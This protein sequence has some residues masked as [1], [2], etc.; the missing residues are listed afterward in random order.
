MAHDPGTMAITVPKAEGGLTTARQTTG[1]GRG[2]QAL[3]RPP[4]AERAACAESCQTHALS[5][6]ISLVQIQAVV[7]SMLR[8]LTP[9]CWS[10]AAAAAKVVAAVAPRVAGGV[11]LRRSA[12]GSMWCTGNGGHEAGNC[13]GSVA[14]RS[15]RSG[16]KYLK[17]CAGRPA[18]IK[19]PV[20]VS[21]HPAQLSSLS[22]HRA[23]RLPSITYGG[24]I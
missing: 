22:S 16:G 11:Y 9:P 5:L 8:R 13:C 18:H 24:L 20:P 23:R 21:R 2:A 6:H 14:A 7:S 3:L 12:C 17:M 4:A 1:Q 19:R 10:S 15:S